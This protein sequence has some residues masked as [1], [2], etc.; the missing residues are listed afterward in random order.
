MRG[1]SLGV[2]TILTGY[3][4]AF[5]PTSSIKSKG[6]RIGRSVSNA[7]SQ[8]DDESTRAEFI[9]SSLAILIPS[10][11]INIANAFDGGVGGLGKTRPVTGVVF[12]DPEAASG[13]GSTSS[14]GDDVTNELLAP[15]GTPAFVTFAAPWVS[16]K[17]NKRLIVAL[18]TNSTQLNNQPFLLFTSFIAAI[19]KKCSRD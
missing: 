15:D 12:R 2:I 9:Y 16:K 13:A 17:G 1:V 19:T 3:G 14:S 7:M 4:W 11:Q 5:T 10:T 6:S 18:T 8:K